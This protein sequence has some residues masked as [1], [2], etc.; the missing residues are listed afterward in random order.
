MLIMGMLINNYL[1]VRIGP[2][3]KVFPIPV[4]TGLGDAFAKKK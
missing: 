2:F 3:T 4:A 1:I